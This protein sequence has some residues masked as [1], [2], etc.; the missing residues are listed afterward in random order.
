MIKNVSFLYTQLMVKLV[1]EILEYVPSNRG[2]GLILIYKGHTYG[3]MTSKGRWYCSKKAKGC[4]AKI[5]TTPDG[6]L[7]KVVQS[8]HNHPPPTLC[9]TNDGKVIRV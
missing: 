3:R 1:P 2:K 4:K 7:V 6:E 5:H 9:R 8:E